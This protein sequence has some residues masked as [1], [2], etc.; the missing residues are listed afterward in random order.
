MG[1]FS[2]G[3]SLLVKSF[4]RLTISFLFSSL[5]SGVTVYVHGHVNPYYA[6]ALV[7]SVI[8]ITIVDNIFGWFSITRFLG[9]TLLS[10][11]LYFCIFPL[12]VDLPRSFYLLFF[13]ALF[14]TNAAYVLWEL[15]VRLTAKQSK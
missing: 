6:Q 7:G 14:L 10:V 9:T 13:L 8:G 11:L 3:G 15:G 1:S 5:F 12:L 4:L 2:P